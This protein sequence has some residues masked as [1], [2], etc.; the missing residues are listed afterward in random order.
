MMEFFLL[1]TALLCVLCMLVAAPL[2]DRIR[3][4]GLV[5]VAMTVWVLWA[6]YGVE[7]LADLKWP[8]TDGQTQTAPATEWE[9]SSTPPDPPTARLGQV[10]DLFGGINAL[11]A[12]LAFAGVGIAAFQ[13]WKSTRIAFKQSIETTFFSAVELHHRIADGLRFD[14]VQL[15]PQE[16]NDLEQLASNAGVAPPKRADPAVGRQ[17]FP[18]VIRA[19]SYGASGAGAYAHLSYNYGVLQN[20]H[21]YVLG[22]YFRNLYQILK[23]IDTDEALD[24]TG[25]QKYASVL[26]AQLSSDELALLMVNCADNT[27]DGGQF[28]AMVVRYRL[29]EHIPATKIGIEYFY[30]GGRGHVVLGDESSVRQYLSEQIVPQPART[31]RG[32]F[33]TN[34][35]FSDL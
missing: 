32:A 8:R 14:R 18:E 26:R 25:R 27:V 20:K 34:P 29:L 11:F 15:F 13:Q 6:L 35:A 23:L 2:P 4:F 3:A 5:A 17:V 9:K 28:R 1:W 21:N 16:Q 10:G 22:H 30:T 24:D 12:A 31:Y 33:G 7:Y 19:I